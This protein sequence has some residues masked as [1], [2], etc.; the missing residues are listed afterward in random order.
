MIWTNVLLT[1][2]SRELLVEA[3]KSHH[4][5]IAEQPPHVLAVGVPDPSIEEA[6]I[7]FG[8]PDPELLKR[9]QKLRWLQLSSAGYTRYDTKNFRETMLRSHVMVT[10]SSG[11]FDEPCAEHIMALLLADARQLYPAYDNQRNDCGWPQNP[12]REKVR[13]LVDQTILIIGFGAIGRRLSEL[14]APYNATVIGYRRT[15]QPNFPV[16]MVNQ[17]GLDDILA[18]ADHVI[19]VLPEGESTI[20][21]FNAAR[22][23][24]MKPGSRYY[25]VG[26]GPTTD[27]DALRKALESNRLQAAYLDVTDPE[28]LPP[29]HY[30]WK[31]QNCYLTPHM[32]GGHVNEAVRNIQHF[33]DNLIRY[34]A[35]KP[36]IDRIY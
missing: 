5:V 26:R 22:F 6:E 21:F 10:N 35:G 1:E 12:L 17:E 8:Q 4:L 7:V 9:S 28:P 33:L 29:D 23:A 11:V 20:G 24:Q 15:P 14:L 30:L 34:D 2:P 31:T 16:P 13:L 19:N 18:K 3:T 32:S 36:L 25:S 27:Q